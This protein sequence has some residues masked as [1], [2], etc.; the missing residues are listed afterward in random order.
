MLRPQVQLERSFACGSAFRANA[1]HAQQLSRGLE[2]HA[3]RQ[4]YPSHQKG[5]A[6]G[7]ASGR[8]VSL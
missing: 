5:P 8:R 7:G 1:P 2:I 4:F 6:W 3:R